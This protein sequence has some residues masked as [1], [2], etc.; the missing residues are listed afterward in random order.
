MYIIFSFLYDH[1]VLDCYLRLTAELSSSAQLKLISAR[2]F[3]WEHKLHGGQALSVHL[4]L[5]RRVSSSGTWHAPILKFE[6][7]GRSCFRKKKNFKKGI[8][9]KCFQ[10]L[11]QW[12]KLRQIMLYLTSAI[13]QLGHVTLYYLDAVKDVMLVVTLAM[14]INKWEDQSRPTVNAALI[15]ILRSGVLSH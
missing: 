2:V 3:D 11:S 8:D 1:P 10:P 7:E 12:A 5:L 15:K 6:E 13:Y 14:Y 9:I 4:C